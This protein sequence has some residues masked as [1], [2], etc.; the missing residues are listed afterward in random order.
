MPF[1]KVAL[2]VL[3]NTIYIDGLEV[4]WLDA[5]NNVFWR[6]SWLNP[7]ADVK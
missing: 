7:G 6:S 5:F 1:L 3:Y 2:E 4:F